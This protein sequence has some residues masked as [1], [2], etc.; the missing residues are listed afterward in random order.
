VQTVSG[1]RRTHADDE[2]TW[3][4]GQLHSTVEV[5]EQSRGTGSGGDGGKG[6]GQGELARA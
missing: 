2:Q 4:V 3:E 5:A 6:A 1:S